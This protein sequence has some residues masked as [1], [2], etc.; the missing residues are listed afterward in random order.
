MSLVLLPIARRVQRR[1]PECAVCKHA[2]GMQ[3]CVGE[4][5]KP[6]AS[7]CDSRRRPL[8]EIHAQHLLHDLLRLP[9]NPRSRRCFAAKETCAGECRTDVNQERQG[10]LFTDRDPRW[11]GAAAQNPTQ[12]GRTLQAD[13]KQKGRRK[14]ATILG[15]AITTRCRLRWGGRH[16]LGTSGGASV[17]R[18]FTAHRRRTERAPKPLIPTPNS[19]YPPT[20]SAIPNTQV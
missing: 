4:P 13:G 20:Q 3:R 5:R 7:S 17:P 8:H 18:A 16:A 9:L 12:R 15:N 10:D 2:S 6:D 14:K 11:K 19:P 1:R